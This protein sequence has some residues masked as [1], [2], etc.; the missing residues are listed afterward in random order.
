MRDLR[1]PGIY[2]L[3]ESKRYYPLRGSS[4]AQVLGYVG[5][6]NQGLGGLEARYDRVVAG[7]PGR[8]TVL[9]DARRGIALPPGL[10]S[11]GAGRRA[12]IST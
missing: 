4:A 2:F 1:L 3:E 12:T 5:T 11:R 7:K 8:R 10:P 9:R 6:D